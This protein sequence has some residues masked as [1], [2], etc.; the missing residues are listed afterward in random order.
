[1]KTGRLIWGLLIV[2]VGVL[3]LAASLGWV[4]WYFLLSLLQL[5]PLALVLIGIYLLLN[6]RQ[7]VLAAVIMAVI[8]IG[9]VVSAWYVWGA[10]GSG[11][12]TRA[13]EGPAAAGVTSASATIEVGATNLTVRGS[14]QGTMVTG[15][16]RSRAEY[17]I[18]QVKTSNRYELEISPNFKRWYWPGISGTD[19]MELF[20]AQGIPWAL[21][22]NAGAAGA[23]LDLTDVTL[24]RLRI[25]TGASSIK[26]KVGD[27]VESGARVDI[28]GG[29]ASY[30]ISLPKDLNVVVRSDSGLSN[31]EVVGFRKAGD[32]TLVHEG[33]GPTVEVT[34]KTGVSSVRVDLY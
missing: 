18:N 9:G 1:M 24:S 31:L 4:S 32:G 10:D 11:L 2:I 5:W 8:L 3:L 20:L 15:T 28:A 33:T 27:V 16:Y 6:R 21:E 17:R 14:A 12:T 25:T 13:I 23:E 30:R 34:V 19:A 26:V 29:V 22:V 7:P